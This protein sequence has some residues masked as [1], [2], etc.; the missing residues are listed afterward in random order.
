MQREMNQLNLALLGPP[1]VRQHEQLLSFAT[2]KALALLLYLAAEG[3]QHR[4]EKI[5]A[6]FWPDSDSERT[7]TDFRG[8][9]IYTWGPNFPER[10]HVVI[11]WVP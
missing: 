7:T 11:T 4:R 2:R 6:L 9:R 3:G 8:C 10:L 1:E 5:T